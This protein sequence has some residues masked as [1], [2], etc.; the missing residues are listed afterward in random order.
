MVEVNAE[1]EA[2]AHFLHSLCSLDADVVARLLSE[3]ARLSNRGCVLAVGRSRIARMLERAIASLSSLD[4]DPA[5][6]WARGSVS[7]VEADVSCELL[8]GSRAAFPV[9]LILCFRD[10]LVSEIR[11]FTYEPAVPN[12]ASTGMPLVFSR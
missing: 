4:C 2:A 12:L 3:D 8:D 6:I 10:R 9:T 5:A 1:N 7:V 11:L